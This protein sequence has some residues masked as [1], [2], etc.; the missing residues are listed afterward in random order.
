MVVGRSSRDTNAYFMLPRGQLQ[1][2]QQG[3]YASF[4]DGTGMEVHQ[5]IVHLPSIAQQYPVVI[6]SQQSILGSGSV[7]LLETV[8]I[9][10]NRPSPRHNAA[11]LAARGGSAMMTT[12]SVALLGSF[13]SYRQMTTTESLGAGF[14]RPNSVAKPTLDAQTHRRAS[15]RPQT[16]P[17]SQQQAAKVHERRSSKLPLTRFS[18]LVC[19]LRRI[20]YLD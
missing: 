4:A 19:R 12:P 10:R 8:A 16:Q 17:P 1:K 13:P 14:Y 20:R 2:K 11:P 6:R 3:G 18:P 15:L 7:S 9:N 5:N